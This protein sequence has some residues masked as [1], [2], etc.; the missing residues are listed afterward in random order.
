MGNEFSNAIA[1]DSK[2][3]SLWAVFS[4]SAVAELDR[5]I[6]WKDGTLVE[7]TGFS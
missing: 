1:E 5:Y 6:G 3:D 2:R 7:G 4:P